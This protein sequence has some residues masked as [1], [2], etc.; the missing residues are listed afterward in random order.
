MQSALLRLEWADGENE[1]PSPGS[2]GSALECTWQCGLM[3]HVEGWG[4]S[5]CHCSGT[6]ERLGLSSSPYPPVLFGEGLL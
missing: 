6:E 1:S 2:E 5:E 3:D 4:G